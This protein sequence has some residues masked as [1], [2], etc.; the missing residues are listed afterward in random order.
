MHVTINTA[1][2]DPDIRDERLPKLVTSIR[3]V[4]M[5]TPG[6]RLT[7]Y[8]EPNDGICAVTVAL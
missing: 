7:V 1:L 6:R 4:G 8:K 5:R 2:K 3:V